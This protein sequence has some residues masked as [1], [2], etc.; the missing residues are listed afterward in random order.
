[1][2]E[3]LSG[4]EQENAQH[5]IIKY[6]T[7]DIKKTSRGKEE[8]ETERTSRDMLL[9]TARAMKT[10]R[11]DALSLVAKHGYS[12]TGLLTFRDTSRHVK[13][14][15]EPTNQKLAISSPNLSVASHNN[16]TLDLENESMSKTMTMKGKRVTKNLTE[17]NLKKHKSKRTKRLSK[18]M[19]EEV[20]RDVLSNKDDV[21]SSGDKAVLTDANKL[22][23]GKKRGTKKATINS[24]SSIKSEAK[25]QN[26]Q[27]LD[28]NLSALSDEDECSTKGS[29]VVVPPLDLNG[30]DQAVTPRTPRSILRYELFFFTFRYSTYNICMF[31]G[32][33]VY[34]VKH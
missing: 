33:A 24:K 15:L 2:A 3:F 8:L 13:F 28:L 16:N 6:K 18:S 7:D 21:L 12:K 19:D 14:D 20:L 23:K 27:D 32:F 17:N 34:K 5:I 31:T 9:L 22:K 4:A 30:L 25:S 10:N 29:G 26:H 1:M 11:P